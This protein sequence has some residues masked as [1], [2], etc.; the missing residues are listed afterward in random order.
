M[1]YSIKD[2][3][4]FTKIKAHTIRIWEQRYNLLEPK[5]TT[6]NIRYYDDDDLK[7]ILNINLLY[8]SGLKISKIAKL[9][10]DEFIEKV[11]EV[12]V[13]EDQKYKAKI[14]E[15]ILC[16]TSFDEKGIRNV[17]E[18]NKEE[19]GLEAVYKDILIPVFIKIGKLWQVNTIDI[20]HEHFFSNIFKFFIIS[21]TEQLPINSKS[22]K[23]AVLF[24]HDNEEHEFSLLINNYILRKAGIK[25]YYFGQKS[26]LKDLELI[27]SSI[28]PDYLLSSFIRVMSDKEFDKIMQGM[29]SIEGKHKTL[30]S[31]N[32]AVSHKLQLPPSFSLLESIDDLTIHI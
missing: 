7:K 28:S 11:T 23:K 1:E 31:G 26:P 27:V 12:I 30:V 19:F 21:S 22:T 32:Q 20:C 5:R 14:D 15:I 2:F 18:K 16:I 24:L 29:L 17:L 3:E 4:N 8:N 9:S 10:N 25:T 6:T 13:G